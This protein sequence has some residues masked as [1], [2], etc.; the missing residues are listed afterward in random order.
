M[1]LLASD[2]AE[3]PKLIG[4]MSAGMAII[5]PAFSK[6]ASAPTKLAEYLACGVPCLGNASVGDVQAVLEERRVGVALPGFTDGQIRSGVRRLIELTADKDVQERCRR[7]AVELY[8]LDRGVAEYETIY[9]RL[10]NGSP[11]HR[12]SA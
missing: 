9:R 8:S 12:I 3:M 6:I 1:E 7:A 11:S 4:R 10:A 5:K 2:H